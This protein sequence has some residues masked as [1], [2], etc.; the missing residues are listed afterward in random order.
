MELCLM[1]NLPPPAVE[2]CVY[3]EPGVAGNKSVGVSR[4]GRQFVREGR[5][6][7]AVRLAR[8][9]RQRVTDVVQRVAE[10][11][12]PLLDGPLAAAVVFYRAKPKSAP[13]TRQTWPDTRPDLSKYLRAIEDPM[14]G[15]LIA[16]DARIVTFLELRKAYPED[17]T[18]EDPRPRAEIR[19][20][21]LEDLTSAAHNTGDAP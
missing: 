10:T 19:L 15:V 7:G 9:W 8:Q 5:S 4:N 12:A 11:G 2:F 16:D 6:A 3:G 14:T 13:K 1:A 17:E 20:W 21:R 18:P